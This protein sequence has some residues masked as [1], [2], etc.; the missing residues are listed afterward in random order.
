MQEQRAKEAPQNEQRLAREAARYD[1]L[2][3]ELAAQIDRC[4]MQGQPSAINLQVPRHSVISP[5]LRQMAYN[6]TYAGKS[7]PVVFTDGSR[8]PRFPAGVLTGSPAAMKL[9]P[10]TKEELLQRSASVVKMGLMSMRHPDL[11]YLVDFYI[12]RNTEL[13]VEEDTMANRE[14]MSFE[15]TVRAL[16]DAALDGGAEIW[17]YQT[18]FEPMIVGV[19]RGVVEVLQRRKAAAKK[20]LVVWPWLFNYALARGIGN[21]AEHER[22]DEEEGQDHSDY[23]SDSPGAQPHFYDPLPPWM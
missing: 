17:F 10:A 11:D 12:T 23:S 14:R 3:G 1:R 13:A 4:L 20:P 6:R 19:Y 22:R 9:T 18:G 2:R 16:S 7:L 15:R 8:P 21:E 5:V